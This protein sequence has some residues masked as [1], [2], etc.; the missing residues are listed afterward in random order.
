MNAPAAQRHAGVSDLFGYYRTRDVGRLNPTDARADHTAQDCRQGAEGILPVCREGF[1]NI[2]KVAACI[3][4]SRAGAAVEHR[5][6]RV[7]K[8]KPQVARAPIAADEACRAYRSDVSHG[9]TRTPSASKRCNLCAG[10]SMGNPAPSASAG[11]ER[12]NALSAV[13]ASVRWTIVPRPVGSISS[14]IP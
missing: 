4:R 1:K 14:T 10:Q 5:S 6:L 2:G 13:P 3:D 7:A 11:R 8:K 9:S 12:L